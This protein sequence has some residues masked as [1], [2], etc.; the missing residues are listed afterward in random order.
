MGLLQRLFS[1]KN[2][3]TEN[4]VQSEEL[5]RLRE[6]DSFIK[7]NTRCFGEWAFCRDSKKKEKPCSTSASKSL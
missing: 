6:L 2:P 7:Q 3:D 5:I 4:I 1:K